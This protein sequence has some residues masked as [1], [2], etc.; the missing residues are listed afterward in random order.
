MTSQKITEIPSREMFQHKEI[1]HTHTHTP[2]DRSERDRGGRD[3]GGE[4]T[5]GGRRRRKLKWFGEYRKIENN[6]IRDY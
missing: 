4:E 6:I 1:T 3:G 2:R 5:G